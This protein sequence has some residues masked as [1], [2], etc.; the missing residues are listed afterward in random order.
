[1]VG[2]ANWLT[3]CLAW[4]PEFWSQ[5]LHSGKTEPAAPCCS[6]TFAS[7]PGHACVHTHKHNQSSVTRCSKSSKIIVSSSLDQWAGKNTGS[8]N[9]VLFRSRLCVTPDKFHVLTT[10]PSVNG[11]TLLIHGAVE[12]YWRARS[13]NIHNTGTQH[14]GILTSV[15]WSP[16]HHSHK[17]QESKPTQAES[18]SKGYYSTL[19]RWQS[20]I[21]KFLIYFCDYYI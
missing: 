18:E 16:H 6:W 13:Q 9:T 11:E 10:Q 8:E 2:L 20:H 4:W 19:Q 14:T 17:C 3:C 1:M 21:W 7:T 12:I 15:I 5:V